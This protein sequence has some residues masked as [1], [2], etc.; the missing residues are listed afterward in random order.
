MRTHR[1]PVELPPAG[2]CGAGAAAGARACEATGARCRRA[3]TIAPVA[4]ATATLAPSAHATPMNAAA[5]LLGNG[6]PAASR[7]L[8]VAQRVTYDALRTPWRAPRASGGS[9]ALRAGDRVAIKLP[10]GSAW[11]SAFLGTMWAGGVAVAVNPRI[12][13][14]EW[15]VILGEAGFRFILAESRDDT[16]AA[17]RERVV[18]VATNFSATREPRHRWRPKPMDAEAPAFWTH[19]SGS[20]GRPKAVVHAHRFALQVERVAAR[21]ARRRRRR[22]S[23]RELQAVLLVSAGQQPVRGTE[24]RRD[25]DPRSAVADRRGRHGDDRGGAADGALQRAFAVSQPVE[26]RSRHAA[27]PN[28]DVRAVRVGRRSAAAE[29]AR[30]VAAADGCSRSSTAMARPKR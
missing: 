16:P 28:A 23:V 9:A 25:G 2:R 19:S 10:D 22:S 18:T 27:S 6:E 12:P 20:S 29:R 26:G 11:V 21:A 3:S 13:A 15:H 5:I 14:D 30:R 7:S 24:A 17:Y 8:A 1:H 4:V